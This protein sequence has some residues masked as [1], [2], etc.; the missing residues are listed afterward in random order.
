MNVGISVITI[1]THG[2]TDFPQCDAFIDDEMNGKTQHFSAQV[3]IYQRCREYTI[4]LC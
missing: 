3:I 2:I 1:Q 4:P